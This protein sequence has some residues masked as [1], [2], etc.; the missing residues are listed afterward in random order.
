MKWEETSRNVVLGA[1]LLEH[2]KIR[3]MLVQGE[4]F[5]DFK[6]FSFIW[7]GTISDLKRRRWIKEVPKARQTMF[8]GFRL[9]DLGLAKAKQH[10]AH[11]RKE[12]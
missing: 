12:R 3:E 4:R 10:A 1:L 9:T 6:D 7:E 11:K 2:P 8:R 5:K